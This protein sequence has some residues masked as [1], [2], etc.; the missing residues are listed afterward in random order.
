LVIIKFFILATLFSVTSFGEK[1]YYV[2]KFKKKNYTLVILLDLQRCRKL[3]NRSILL[4]LTSKGK[5][6]R[7]TLK[8]GPKNCKIYK[9]FKNKPYSLKVLYFD[10]AN[11]KIEDWGVIKESEK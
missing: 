6:F 11:L 9:K 1:L 10:P 7:K 5:I 2:W 4:F 3:N 8:R